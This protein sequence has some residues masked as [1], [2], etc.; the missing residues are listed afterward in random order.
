VAE[1]L[2]TLRERWTVLHDRLLSP[3]LSPVNLDHVVVGPGG[4]FFIDAKNWGGA[5]TAW[6]GNLFQHM[7]AGEARQSMSKHQEV[8]KV[9]GMAAYMAAESGMPVTPVICLAG[10]SESEFGEPQLI[11]GVWV[12]PASSI[13]AWLESRPQVLQ[14]EQVERASVNLMTSFPST[15]TDALL[16]AAMGAANTQSKAHR[17]RTPRARRKARST[18]PAPRRSSGVRRALRK[19]VGA[20]VILGVSLAALHVLPNLLAG[21]LADAVTRGVAST[22]APTSA[23]TR[24]ASASPHKSGAVVK[25]PTVKATVPAAPVS[26]CA[27]LTAAQVGK[28]V[29]R[30]VQP[31]ADRSGCSWGTRL[32][33]A[34]TTLVTVRTKDEHAAYEGNF[35]TSQSQRRTV[36]GAA[37]INWKPATGLWVATGQPIGFGKRPSTAKRD[38]EVLVSKEALNVS[39]D[40]G[41]ALATSLAAAVNAAL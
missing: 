21:G 39:D 20:V 23:P 41:R 4:I 24:K 1:E 7:G 40:R 14:R 30:K 18:Q 22:P 10:R 26:T 35:V 3:G 29:G 32:D 37:Y 17:S 27:N 28:I 9:H 11:R 31:V 16:L 12:V 15:T 25:K 34:T 6:Q 8:A 38:I 36:F 33:D 5:V 19:L 2:A 13:S